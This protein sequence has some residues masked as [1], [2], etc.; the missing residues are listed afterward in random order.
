MVINAPSWKPEWEATQQHFMRWWRHEGGVL[1]FYGPPLNQDPKARETKG[2]AKPATL[3]EEHTDPRW[4]AWNQ[5][6]LLAHKTYPADNLPIAFVE[7]GTLQL[8]ASL[9]SQVEFAPDTVWYHP[10]TE[11]PEEW[12]LF[13][14]D[15]QHPWWRTYKAI[16]LELASIN[17]SEFLIGA[18]AFGSNLDVLAALRG[19]E[20]L[21][22]DLV[23]R[24]EWVN[25]KLEA[26]N[27]CFYA[28][29][30]DYYEV[31]QLADGSSTYAFFDIWGLGKVSQVQCD[32]SAMI[33]P[34]M[35]DEFVVPALT[36][37][38]AWL[39]QALYHLDGPSCI[40]HLDHLLAIEPLDAIQWTPGAGQPGAGDPQWFRLYER[41]LAAGKS[42]QILGVEAKQ[43]PQL[44]K[45]FGTKGVYLS[46]FVQDQAELEAVCAFAGFTG[47][48]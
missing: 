1:T 38:C 2:P 14:L 21:L 41:I 3:L 8:A 43:A 20:N 33:S 27:Q 6:N 44:L 30:D 46:V 18:P 31:L 22:F 19:A 40:C 36:E 25:A 12:P 5:R 45:R 42:V 13:T 47:C 15:K 16:L 34:D 11:P 28:A 37:Q 35:F 17:H 26:I 32:F 9:G 23:D 10:R 48:G 29:F 7:Y 39:D 24:P 4:F